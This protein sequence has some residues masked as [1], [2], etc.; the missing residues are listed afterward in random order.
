[1]YGGGGQ[2]DGA[3]GGAA[4]SNAL[5]GGGGFMPSQSTAVPE[6]SGSGTA[7]VPPN[8]R[9]IFLVP[10]FG[11]P[12][13]ALKPVSIVTGPERAGAAPAHR[14]A[15]HGR[16]AGQRRQVQFRGQWRRGVH[17]TDINIFR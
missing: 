12:P 5:F 15:D 10:F 8:L 9:F 2:Y 3:G 1:M 16:D 11:L 6:S 4:N 14:E 7:K 17:G 13:D